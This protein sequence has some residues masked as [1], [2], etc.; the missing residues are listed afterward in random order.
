MCTPTRFWRRLVLIF[1]SSLQFNSLQFNSAR[2]RGREIHGA[3]VNFR[4]FREI[5]GRRE[6][7]RRAPTEP[8]LMCLKIHHLEHRPIRLIHVELHHPRVIER[9]E[10]LAELGLGPR[11]ARK[12]RVLHREGI[13]GHA[14]EV[15][16][17]RH[18]ERIQRLAKFAER[19]GHA[20]E[21]RELP[22]TAQRPRN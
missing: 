3:P 11:R 20:V 16:S 7:R 8:G 9:D 1:F 4:N 13:P 12:D 10:R 21:A 14:T 22:G 18:D 15:V 5:H 19:P 6:L 17:V 2:A